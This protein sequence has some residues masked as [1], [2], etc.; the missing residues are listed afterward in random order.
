MLLSQKRIKVSAQCKATIKMFK[1][2]R[3]GSGKLDFIPATDEN[4][5]VFDAI[6]YALLMECYDEL[7]NLPD[8]TA[9]RPVSVHV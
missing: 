4:K 8:A 9:R 1:D 6:T 2:L 7:T 5:H 3:K